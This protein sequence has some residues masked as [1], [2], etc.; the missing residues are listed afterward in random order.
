[1]R[2]E[3]IR[4]CAIAALL[5]ASP[6]AAQTESCEAPAPEGLPEIQR[7]VSLAALDR[8]LAACAGVAGCGAEARK[9]YGLTRVDGYVLDD[10]G[11]DIILVGQ[12]GPGEPL[13]VDDLV[14]ALR[15]T[16]RHYVRREG[17]VSYYSA[18]AVSIDP[19]PDTMA[20]L[21]SLAAGSDTLPGDAFDREWVARCETQQDVRVIGIPNSRTA[22][23]MVE[24]DYLMKRFVNGQERIGDPEFT[25][26]SDLSLALA[27]QNVLA[28]RAIGGATGINRF[29]FTAGPSV[30]RTDAGAAMI[31]R[32]D[33]VLLD[34]AEHLLRTGETVGTGQ[35]NPLAREFSCKFSRLYPVLA[36]DAAYPV[37]R[38]LADV[39]RWVALAWLMV[40]ERAFARAGFRP[41]HLI[42]RHVLSQVEVPETLPGIAEI[43]RWTHVTED[44][45]TRTRTE[46][47]LPSCGGVSIEYNNL[48]ASIVPDRAG[49]LTH[50]EQVVILLRPDRLAAFWDILLA[51]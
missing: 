42:E 1:M 45:S 27:K 51:R 48:E 22:A 33:V 44:G 12:A 4:L 19:R 2:S 20:R 40:R 15:N 23:T 49:I 41:E 8:E 38:R 21:E 9:V 37:Y 25:S 6:A 10:A 13:D 30:F 32:A 28:G 16:L 17:N 5:L 34:E 11:A 35:S 46:L 3:L 24:A 14:V 7:A 43:R 36:A 50:L 47:S 18:P 26:L 29:W 39:F 31:E